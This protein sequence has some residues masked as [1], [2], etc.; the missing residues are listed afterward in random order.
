MYADGVYV[1]DHPMGP[2]PISKHNPIPISLAVIST[3]PVME[4]RCSDQVGNIGIFGSMALPINMH[5]ERRSAC[6]LLILDE[7]GTRV[8]RHPFW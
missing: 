2:Y 4:V 8:L 3:V 7:D 1:V 5:W 6:S